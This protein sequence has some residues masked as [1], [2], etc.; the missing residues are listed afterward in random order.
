VFLGRE[1]TRKRDYSNKTAVKVDE[2]MRNIL[3]ACR[4]R[5]ESIISKRED[6]LH[7]MAETLLEHETLDGGQVEQLLAG[8]TLEPAVKREAASAQD[9]KDEAGQAEETRT[10]DD[11]APAP[12]PFKEPP[13]AA[14]GV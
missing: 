11:K 1:L 9:A 7:R 10:D 2:D 6:V 13:L 4:Q 5:A 3:D 12:T 14:P 8:Q